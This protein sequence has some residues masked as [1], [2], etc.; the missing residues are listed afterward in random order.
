VND[1]APER[2]V[3][4][5]QSLN[6]VRKEVRAAP[7]YPFTPIHAP[8]KLDQ[9]ESALDFPHDL[10]KRALEKMLRAEWNRY[11][12]IHADGLR[13][14]LGAFEGWDADGVLIAPGSNVLIYALTQIAGIGQR[15]ATVAPAFP[16]YALGARLLGSGLREFQLGPDF[17]LPMDEMLSELRSGGPG[18]LYLAEPH[19]PSGALHDLS[20]IET[21][22]E[23]ARDGWIVVLDEAY[24]QYAGRDHKRLA[25]EYSNVAI[26]RTF[27]KAWGLG[28]VRLGY[29]LAQPSL[30]QQ[31]QKILL[32]FNIGVLHQAVLEVALE[33]PQYVQSRVEETLLER[34]RVYD[35]LQKHPSWTVY[36]SRANF[37]LIR[38]QDAPAAHRALLEKG[39][40]VRR[41]DSY[42]GLTG[43]VRVSIGTPQE[44]DAF[45][46]AALEIA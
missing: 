1:T 4:E 46:K 13:Q 14:K 21:I 5:M 20:Q 24:H 38:T 19:A 34:E 22:L 33:H 45:L 41:Q 18:L 17:A 25:L 43:C 23:A 27:S 3:N 30:A 26:L 9:N 29:L 16:L 2:E 10:K 8:V 28:G 44:N 12:N 42:A 11:P 39:V 36:P 35:A 6:A 31:V 7:N 37:L 15:V 40:L 32:P